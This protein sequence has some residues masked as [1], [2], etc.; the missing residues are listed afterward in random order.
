MSKRL[1]SSW[2]QRHVND[3]YV[4]RAIKEGYRAR[5]AYKLLEINE[6]TRI[7][8]PG[9][10]AIDLGSA[11]GGWS[12]VLSKKIS[13][14][15]IVSLDLLSMNPVPNCEFLKM[16][17]RQEKTIEKIVEI[18][19]GGVQLIVSDLSPNHSGNTDLDCLEIIDLNNLVIDLAKKVILNGGN[20][21]MKMLMGEFEDDHFVTYI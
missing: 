20:V 12:Q 5:S 11:P 19:P 7:L 9:I 15:K 1:F 6:K 10:R 2:M 8:K 13:G 16:D 17:M 4:K 14:G 18:C 3:P 21:V